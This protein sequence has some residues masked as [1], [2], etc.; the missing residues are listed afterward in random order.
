[1]PRFQDFADFEFRTCLIGEK[2]TEV[3]FSRVKLLVEEKY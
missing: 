3:N 2:K 1:M